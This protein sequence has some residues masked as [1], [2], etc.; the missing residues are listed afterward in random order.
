MWND[1]YKTNVIV[2]YIF[3]LSRTKLVGL[4]SI[5]SRDAAVIG[6]TAGKVG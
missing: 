2:V 3:Y 5:S 6:T 4:P 1:E